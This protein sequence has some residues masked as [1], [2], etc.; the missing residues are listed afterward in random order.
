[1]ETTPQEIRSFERTVRVICLK[2][3]GNETDLEQST[4]AERLGMMWQLALDAWAF[5]GEPVAE[6]RLPRH[7]GRILR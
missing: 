1:M 5:M 2:E 3:Q 6:P 7:I 4:P